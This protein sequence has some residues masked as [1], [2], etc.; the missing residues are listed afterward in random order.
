MCINCGCDIELVIG[1]YIS[2]MAV[3]R[4]GVININFRKKAQ[5]VNP[6]QLHKNQLRIIMTI[7]PV[8]T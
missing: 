6:A 7:N 8:F 5:P 2:Y 4:M 1:D 3:A